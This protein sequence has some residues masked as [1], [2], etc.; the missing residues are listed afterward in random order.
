MRAFASREPAPQAED[1]GR[2]AS[3][4][5]RRAVVR[6]CMISHSFYESDNRVVR[7]AEALASRGDAVEVLALRRS[8]ELPTTEVIN[9]VVVHRIQNRFGAWNAD[10]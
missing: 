8:P 9:G 2:D 5:S 1:L 10:H 6:V 4:P 7:Y 3:A